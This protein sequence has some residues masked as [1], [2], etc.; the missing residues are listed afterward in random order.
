[1]AD[2]WLFDYDT[3]QG[4]P[5][6]VQAANI[7][8][9]LVDGPDVVVVKRSKPLCAVP[10][11]VYGSKPTDGGHLLLSN[12]DREQLLLVEPQAEPW[13]RPFLNADEFLNGVE[14]WCLWLKDC[15][16][17]ELRRMPEVLK[18]VEAV[19]QMRVAS[20]KAATRGRA[21]LPMLFGEIRQPG[22]EY[23]LA[24]AHTSEN[25][26]YIPMGYLP[27]S[28][29]CGNANLTIPDATLYHFGVLQSTMHMAWM[30][31]VAGRL[32]SDYRYSATIV[33]NTFPWP[34]PNAKQ[35]NAI[36]TAAQV[37]FDG[38]ALFPEARR[39]AFLFEQYQKMLEQA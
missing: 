3:I 23:L 4:E 27:A 16:P 12:Q 13:I 30:R 37:L 25:R 36:E 35:Q 5:H 7:N 8:P 24:P 29:I 15:P 2:K 18:R 11:M 9:Y 17:Q 6:A 38:R 21:S 26:R 32:K 31:A 39:V 14:R 33:Y 20:V 1:V 28:V 34:A 19:R 22:S 10:E